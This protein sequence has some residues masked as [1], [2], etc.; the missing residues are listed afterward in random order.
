VSNVANLYKALAEI[1]AIRGQMARAAKFRG[2]GPATLAA[3][4]ALALASAAAQSYWLKR[5]GREIGLYLAIWISTA[6][7]SVIII[8]AE[9]IRRAH[10]V[11]FGLAKEMILSAVEQFLPAIVAGLLLTVVLVRYTPQSLWML[12]GLWQ[13][14]FS[15]GVFASCQFLPRPIFAVGVWYLATGL[16]CIVLGSGEWAFSPWEMG[17]SFGVGQILVAAV[18]HYGEA[19]DQS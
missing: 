9:T 6:A 19:D 1:D 15:L 5:P 14:I 10:R 13:V 16:T 4:G 7:V 18:L 12:P 2:Y 8:A 3:T 17:V 11:H